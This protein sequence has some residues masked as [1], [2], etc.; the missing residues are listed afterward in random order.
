MSLEGFVARPDGGAT[1][2]FDWYG[3]GTVRFDRPA[4]NMVSEVTPRHPIGVAVFVVS[5]RGPEGWDERHDPSLTRNECE[6]LH[7]TQTQA[8]FS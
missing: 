7:S 6:A 3:N 4:N 2:I 1:H 8:A 5:H